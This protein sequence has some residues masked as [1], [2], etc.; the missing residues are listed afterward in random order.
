MFDAIGA[1]VN[2]GPTDSGVVRVELI[3]GFHVR[4]GED[5]GFE[6]RLGTRAAELVQ[7]LS[8]APRRRLA[9]EQVVEA[10]WPQLDADAGGANL[11]KAA[12]LAR[13][14]L[15]S[16]DAVVLRLGTV[17]LFP[18]R[19]VST[20]LADLEHEA[21]DALE[22]EDVDAARALAARL[23]G[24]LLPEARYRT[25]AGPAR[26]RWRELQLQVLRLAGEWERLVELDRSDEAAYVEL[27]RRE[28]AAGRR[29]S[30][31]RWFG[32]LRSAL[33]EE[34]AIVP[35]EEARELYERCIEGLAADAPAVI[36]RDLELARLTAL[37][38][39]PSP[40]QALVIRGPAGIGKTA[41]S[42][43]LASLARAD[44]WFAVAV[45]AT[46]GGASYAPLVEVAE[47]LLEVQPELT[48][49]VGPRARAVLA[50]LLPGLDA[51][52]ETPET[53][54][55]RHRVIGALRRLLLA[56]A[57]GSP[58]LLLIDDAHLAD[59]ATTDALGQLG[60][61]ADAASSGSRIVSALAYRPEAAPEALRRMVARLSRSDRCCEIDLGP[62]G[63]DDAVALAAA[64]SPVRREAQAAERIVELAQGN[65]FLLVEL[66]SSAVAGVPAL[67]RTASDAIAARFVD[68][69][70][71][72][73]VAADR[74]AL[75]S[76]DLAAAEAMAL[77]SRDESE[78]NELLD[79]VLR[80]GVI[81][82]A[83]GRY[84]F[85]HEL[86]RQALLERIPPHRRIA[87]QAEAATRLAGAG[88]PAALV[89]ARW[90]D[91]GRPEE[92]VPWLLSAAREAF[93]LGAFGDALRH[94]EPL[95]AHDPTHVEALRLRAE[96][97]DARG[98]E[99]APAAYAAAASVAE[100]SIAQELLAKRALATIKLGDPDRGLELL[101][102]VEPSTLDGRVAHALAHA[103]AAALGSADPKLGTELAARARR[104][105]LEAGD[106]EAVTVASW[107]HAAAAHAR[108]ELPESI[109]TD[110]E[111]TRGLG[112]LAISVFDG[113]LCMTQRLLYGSRPYG[114]VIAFADSLAAEADR[115]GAAR[116]KAFAVTIRGEAKLLSGQLGP[117]DADLAAGAQLH[118]EIGAVTGEAFALQRRA[119][120]ALHKGD[121]AAAVELLDR[122]LALARD[123]DVGFHLFDR[124]YGTLVGMAGEPDAGLAALEE[125][126]EAVRGPSETCP[127]C[128]ITLAAP[129]AI[130]AARAGEIDK[131]REW[132]GTTEYL[133]RVVM[134]LPAWDAALEEVEGHR[135]LAFGAPGEARERFNRAAELFGEAGQPLDRERC[136]ALAERRGAR[137]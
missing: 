132:A 105:A 19:A 133:A 122:A 53:P 136:L 51:E 4:V 41:I 130:A 10:L 75:A 95:L 12:H 90:L 43:D 73:V 115:L 21:H 71:T 42:R 33:R 98:E 37:L 74:L 58:L 116:G 107:A 57:D 96:A 128:R 40:P 88:A 104:L 45:T 20:D 22:R 63:T 29:S 89:A 6:E 65:P 62:L 81:V 35:G 3:G 48:A 72:E 30:A 64:V 5:V 131:A 15:G 114:D 129:A 26:E 117:A 137:A 14:A 99:A 103:G 110:L 52:P 102:G 76:G 47:T 111:N 120:V 8:L 13:R 24:E 84:R 46:E 31:I 135:T 70:P 18:D 55:T 108:G 66:A 2:D 112:R 28:L 109:R 119:E 94:L 78:A 123:S 9:R 54:L 16:E 82:V 7:L 36:G 93:R 97:M 32:R 121:A 87:L 67:V 61:S 92:A 100:E 44:G 23:T 134:R 126:E 27:M 83:D 68:L 50:E 124:I 49:A 17:S 106:P 25:W 79:A 34:L 118:R 11:R 86:V 59:E 80:S 39:E 125:A 91:A 69:D 38:R 56:A 101:E 1:Q 77:F 85:R 60:S 127:T 113:Q